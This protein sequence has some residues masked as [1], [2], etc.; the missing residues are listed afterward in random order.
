MKISMS[1]AR[2][3]A[4][5]LAKGIFGQN[6]T[7]E[8]SITIGENATI[9]IIRRGRKYI[10]YAANNDIMAKEDTR[11]GFNENI[12]EEALAKIIINVVENSAALL[13]IPLNMEKVPM[14]SEQTETTDAVSKSESA[15][16]KADASNDTR[17]FKPAAE[18]AAEPVK[19]AISPEETAGAD[20]SVNDTADAGSGFSAADT[21]NPE[22]TGDSE[23]GPADDFD[24]ENDPIFENGQPIE[25]DETIP[26]KEED[27]YD[28]DEQEDNTMIET[29]KTDKVETAIQANGL[30]PSRT[31]TQKLSDISY[32]SSL[33]GG[34]EDIQK[35]F[36]PI[37]R[38]I[39]N[40]DR[41]LAVEFYI[42]G[43]YTLLPLMGND[44]DAV[45]EATGIDKRDIVLAVYE[46]QLFE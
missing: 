29:A 25:P 23:T 7:K 9:G 45:A 34:S 10:L 42:R 12:S 6:E 1:D 40:T 2:H 11:S 33:L 36:E 46:R 5:Y 8:V 24:H 3:L 35:K 39:A 4:R 17:N 18:K 20:A 19:A 26:V 38:T 21:Q 43:I 28:N 15:K 13:E 30:M 27:F 14:L 16:Q 31:D 22:E 41:E 32:I 37:F 44:I